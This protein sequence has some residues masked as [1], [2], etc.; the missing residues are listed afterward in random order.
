MPHIFVNG[1]KREVPGEVNLQQLL[2][3]LSL[4]AQRISVELNREVVSRKI[5]EQT[6]VSEGDSIEI[7]HFVGGG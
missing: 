3:Y 7:V 1:E 2:E 6:A 4:P 5:W